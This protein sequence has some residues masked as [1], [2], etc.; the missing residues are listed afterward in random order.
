M[1]NRAHSR[2]RRTQQGVVMIMALLVLVAITIAAIALTRSVDSA[3]LVAGNLAF[4]KAATRAA[5]KGIEQAIAFVKQKA[6]DGT[7]GTDDTSSGYFATLGT[8]DK[9]PAGTTWQAF[10]GTHYSA[11]A[12]SMPTDALGNTVSFVIHRACAQP[13]VGAAGLCVE[14]PVQMKDDGNS[15][16]AGEIELE[17][18]SQ[19]YYRITVRVT[20]PRRT[21]SYVQAHIAL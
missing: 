13:F 2:P 3:T 17:S 7:L 1:L 10:F 20:G 16:E 21:E 12:Y 18:S 5:D 8:A 9:P 14:S 6:T 4:K 15:Q 19:V 11:S